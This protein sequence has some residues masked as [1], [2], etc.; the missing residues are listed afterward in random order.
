MTGKVVSI[1]MIIASGRRNAQVT[2]TSYSNDAR[3]MMVVMM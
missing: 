1:L 2:S 3:M